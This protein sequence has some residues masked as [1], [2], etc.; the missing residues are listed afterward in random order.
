M[1]VQRKQKDTLQNL[2]WKNQTEDGCHTAVTCNCVKRYKKHYML[3]NMDQSTAEGIFCDENKK[4]TLGE[5]L[6]KP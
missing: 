6:D 1:A 5:S 4:A 2:D 3:T